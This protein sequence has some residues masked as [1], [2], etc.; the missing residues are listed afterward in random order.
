MKLA[1]TVEKQLP[2]ELLDHILSYITFRD[3]FNV[4]LVN[5]TWY[6]TLYSN[7]QN[8]NSQLR[9]Y[10]DEKMTLGL[11][12]HRVHANLDINPNIK[13]ANFLNQKTRHPNLSRARIT[14][15]NQISPSNLAKVS[16]K[17]AIETKKAIEKRIFLSQDGYHILVFFQPTVRNKAILLLG[18]LLLV[19]SIHNYLNEVSFLESLL[20]SP[21]LLG[22]GLVKFAPFVVAPSFLFNFCVNFYDHIAASGAEYQ[23]EIINGLDRIQNAAEQSSQLKQ[24][25]ILPATSLTISWEGTEMV[26]G[27][28]EV[29]AY[30]NCKKFR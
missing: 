19:A 25:S 15:L 30:D 1:K 29:D 20:Q 27:Y 4:C 14:F 2:I 11:Q 6:Q 3:L 13:V 8:F 28:D 26:S 24:P 17:A 23:N 22:I 5:K 16:L 9:N 21:Y 12:E 18:N 7:I 10:I